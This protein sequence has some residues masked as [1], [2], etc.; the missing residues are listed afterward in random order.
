MSPSI[1]KRPFQISAWGV[2]PRRQAIE[3][4]RPP[5]NDD[6]VS[7]ISISRF[8]QRLLDRDG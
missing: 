8:F 5:P 1:A 6:N 2:N 4:H 7:W 3:F